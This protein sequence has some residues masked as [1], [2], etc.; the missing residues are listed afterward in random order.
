LFQNGQHKT[1]TDLKALSLTYLD[2]VSQAVHCLLFSHD[3]MFSTAKTAG[4]TDAD[5]VPQSAL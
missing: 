5:T 3:L 4:E 1:H 2:A